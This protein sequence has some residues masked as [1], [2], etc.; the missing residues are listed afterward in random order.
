M[1]SKGREVNISESTIQKLI[2]N[3]RDGEEWRWKRKLTKAAVKLRIMM[4]SHLSTP[5][6]V[7]LLML[8]LLSNDYCCRLL[9]ITSS[10]RSPSSRYKPGEA[11]REKNLLLK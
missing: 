2:N 1:A 9:V 5:L 6:C 10:Y 4:T 3:G 11:G 8:T 7:R